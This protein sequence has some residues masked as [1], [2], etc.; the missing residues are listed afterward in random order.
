[1]ISKYVESASSFSGEIDHLIWLVTLIVGFWFFLAEAVFLYLIVRYTAQDGVKAQ[2]IAGEDPKE[3]R[4]VAWP[5][6]LT[7]GFDVWIIIAAIQVW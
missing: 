6:Y 1:M 5:H 3:K 2:Y 7:L 4:W